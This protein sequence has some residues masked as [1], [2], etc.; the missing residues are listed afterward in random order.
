[1]LILVGLLFLIIMIVIGILRF[2]KRTNN[3]EE[4]GVFSIIKWTLAGFGVL[5]IF[6]FIDVCN[7]GGGDKTA[8]CIVSILFI[9]GTLIS[10]IIEKILIGNNL[11]KQKLEEY[12]NSKDKWE[13]LK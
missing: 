6:S 13:E 2:R 9:L 3:E 4:Y 11:R 10:T 5:L 7:N 8:L 1:M 12:N